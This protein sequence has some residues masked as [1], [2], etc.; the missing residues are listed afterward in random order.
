MR[1][2]VLASPGQIR[3]VLGSRSV[4]LAGEGAGLHAR[5]L[6]LGTARRHLVEVDPFLAASMGRLA[7]RRRRT[8]QRGDYLQAEPVYIRPP[9]AVLKRRAAPYAA[10]KPAR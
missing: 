3:G 10:P 1:A 4:W 7:L 8:W 2:P 9:D 6:R 5:E